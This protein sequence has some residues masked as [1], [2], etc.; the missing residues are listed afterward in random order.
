MFRVRHVAFS[1]AILGV[2]AS[3]P[4]D[5]AHARGQA[6]LPAHPSRVSRGKASAL[7]RMVD[8]NPEG[9]RP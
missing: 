1:L 2:A 8:E 5:F 6:P 9:R 3:L 4:I 7:V